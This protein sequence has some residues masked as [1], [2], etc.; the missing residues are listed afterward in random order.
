MLRSNPKEAKSVSGWS[1]A[2][3]QDR[4]LG[5]IA[6][7]QQNSAKGNE[8]WV[9]I[10]QDRISVGGYRLESV[11]GSVEERLGTDARI[12]R[13]ERKIIGGLRGFFGRECFVVEAALPKVE[14]ASAGDRGVVAEQT[15]PTVGS[16]LP[17]PVGLSG[18]P[19]PSSDGQSFAKA[20]AAALAEV[21]RVE[22]QLDLPEASLEVAPLPD[23]S[24]P[25]SSLPTAE[26]PATATTSTPEAATAE[27]PTPEPQFRS[28]AAFLSLEARYLSREDLEVRVSELMGPVPVA[29][30][31]GILAVVGDPDECVAAAR[32]LAAIQGADPGEVLVMSPEPV[33]GHPSWMCVTSIQD[34]EKRRARWSGDKRLHIVAV[35]LNAGTEGMEWACTSLDALAPDQTRLAVPGWRRAEDLTG[36]LRSL[37]PITALDLVGPVDPDAVIGFLD[38]YVPVATID[39]EPAT[40]G[41]WC[42]HLTQETDTA[43]KLI[44][45]PQVP[46]SRLEQVLLDQLLTI[47]NGEENIR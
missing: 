25:D 12:I 38:L 17:A 7:R 30:S 1:T 45:L 4:L 9:E 39:G 3:L 29:P 26:P 11:L 36:R 6:E 37:A 27:P 16:G 44:E 13:T 43:Q 46:T 2:G 24:H 10:L 31:S 18:N 47:S 32:H 15:E 28:E 8:V 5:Q 33:D 41:L 34:C 40:V 21:E 20:L 42:E 19:V 35:V 14:V 23:S 22:S